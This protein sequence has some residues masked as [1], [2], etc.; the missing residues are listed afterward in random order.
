M[1]L[2]MNFKFEINYQ[3][4]HH[5]KNLI[6]LLG[7]LIIPNTT[8]ATILWSG[9]EDLDFPNGAAVCAETTAGYF[10]VGYAR[11]A[12]RPCTYGT[13]AKSKPF[14]GGAVTS[15]WISAQ[16]YFVTNG[17]ANARF[18]GL[19]KSGTNNSLFVGSSASDPYKIAIFT[20][21]GTTYTQL[22]LEAVGSL[23]SSK[24]HRIDMQ[25]INY[26]AAGTVNIYVSG[27]GL[28]VGNGTPVLTYTGDLTVGGNTN[29]DSVFFNSMSTIN[30]GSHSEFIVSDLDSRSMNLVT[31]SPNANGDTNAWSGGDYTN[32]DDNTANDLTPLVGST[33]N[34]RFQANLSDLPATSLAVINVKISAR[35][36]TGG[37]GMTKL[38]LGVKT[39]GSA[40]EPAAVSLTGAWG[41]TETYYSTNPV[42]TN[43]W[44]SGEITNL[45]IS[46]FPE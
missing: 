42:T 26:G 27:P 40:N 33:A 16:T 30:G 1:K 7:F 35:S 13:V 14:Q 6:F 41:N 21:N 5:M 29:L 9:G 46:M 25:V 15:A 23:Q 19:G 22:A 39:N 2:F 43:P 10:R 34:A 17:T 28:S 20:F 32:L 4:G 8:N 36:S 31:L 12:V 18:F 45:Q 38:G 11:L 44:T 24:L 3:G 37:A